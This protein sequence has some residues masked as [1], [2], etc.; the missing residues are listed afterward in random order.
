ME[1]EIK[2][3]WVFIQMRLNQNHLK[4]FLLSDQIL[5]QENYFPK[6]VAPWKIYFTLHF[7]F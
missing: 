3:F 1:D 6:P 4:F 7:S 5:E 2:S